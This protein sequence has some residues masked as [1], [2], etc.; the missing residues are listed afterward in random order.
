LS[1]QAFYLS[2]PSHECAF[3]A[4]S[5]KS[6]RHSFCN[7]SSE[8]RC[9]KPEILIPRTEITQISVKDFNGLR[10]G[11]SHCAGFG[12]REHCRLIEGIEFAD[13]PCDSVAR[14]PIAF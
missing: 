7:A 8:D 11:A 4:G 3:S 12:P 9:R 6:L 14:R 1:G 2:V 13:L 10:L 5:G